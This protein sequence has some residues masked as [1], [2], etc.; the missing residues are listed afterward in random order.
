MFVSVGAQPQ[1]EMA[2]ESDRSL[3]ATVIRVAQDTQAQ[4]ENETDC[5]KYLGGAGACG[6]QKNCT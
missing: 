4:Q 6:L 3:S 1:A 5:V 2:A